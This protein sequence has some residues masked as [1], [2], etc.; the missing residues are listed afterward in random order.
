MKVALFIL[1]GVG[2]KRSVWTV[3]F[4][5]FTALPRHFISLSC[6][7]FMAVTY[8]NII[9]CLLT[10]QFRPRRVRCGF[11]LGRYLQL[12]SSRLLRTSQHGLFLVRPEVT[13]DIDSLSI[14]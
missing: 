1:E 6:Q 13:A 8:G 2:K 14:Y 3:A 11:R 10:L 5:C 7:V 4:M 9:A 12:R